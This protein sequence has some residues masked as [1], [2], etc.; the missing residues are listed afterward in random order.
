MGTISNRCAHPR[1]RSI[2]L[3]RRRPQSAQRLLPSAFVG[4]NCALVL[5][6][7]YAFESDRGRNQTMKSLLGQLRG[8]CFRLLSTLP[9]LLTVTR[10]L[11]QAPNSLLLATSQSG[12]S[13]QHARPAAGLTWMQ[14]DQGEQGRR[15]LGV[16]ATGQQA[17]PQCRQRSDES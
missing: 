10:G 4:G 8:P 7:Y 13:A 16:V 9:V 6:E 15:R 14:T 5:G 1:S 3:K 11:G 17:R 12:C 2:S